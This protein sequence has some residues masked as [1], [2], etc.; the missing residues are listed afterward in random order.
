MKNILGIST[1]LRNKRFSYKNSLVDEI[2]KIKNLKELDLFIKNQ[3][4][5]TFKDIF[6]ANKN[7]DFE[8]KYKELKKYK[9]NRGLSNS[10]ASL[11]YAL[12]QA[13]QE[14]KIEINYISLSNVFENEDR[15]TIRYFKKNFLK[16]NGLLIS[17]PVYFGDRGSLTQRM[18]EFINSDKQC[19]A[20]AEKIIFGGLAVGA[21]RNGGQETTL[22]FQILDFLS[23]NSK[24]IGNGHDTTA[25]YGGTL[26]AGDIGK[27]SDDTYGIKTAL[28][29]GKN[30]AQTLN[31]INFNKNS[32]IKIK[33]KIKCN[34]FILQDNKK[35]EC[36]NVVKKL[37]QNK[38]NKDIE[39]KIFRV[40]E[41]KIHK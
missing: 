36:Y 11:V 41:E 10:E 20:H 7:L 32:R 17:G 37:I 22:I 16:C 24:V 31:K 1:S 9:G 21:K 19:M 18:I 29:T 4:K 5:I 34:V 15:D 13:Y 23:M 14:K 3:I 2:K 38:S 27:V 8:E 28:S 30:M 40:F 35:K 6:N 25:Q 39:F 12:W 26:A 33:R